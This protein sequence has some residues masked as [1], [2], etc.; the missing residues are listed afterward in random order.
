MLDY[1]KHAKK[2]LKS[3]TPL[4][5]PYVLVD[6][7]RSINRRKVSIFPLL[8][9]NFYYC[10]ALILCNSYQAGLTHLMPKE[11]PTRTLDYLL[12]EMGT[13]S[14]IYAGIVEAE[15]T[16]NYD[17]AKI[18]SGLNVPVHR[19]VRMKLEKIENTQNIIPRDVLVDPSSQRIYIHSN[20]NLQIIPLMNN[21]NP[22][23]NTYSATR[24]EFLH[25][26]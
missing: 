9:L 2:E 8:S 7:G 10:R 19:Q 23:F 21:L 25:R 11:N 20:G 16:Y 1:I 24:I 14:P 5:T 4:P 15:T 12:K 22:F 26:C 13:T 6:I 17:L 3:G 18:C